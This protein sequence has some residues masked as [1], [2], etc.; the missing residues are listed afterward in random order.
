MDNSSCQISSNF[1]RF[2]NFFFYFKLKYIQ[3]F[4]SIPFKFQLGSLGSLFWLPALCNEGIRLEY[5]S[6]CKA[7]DFLKC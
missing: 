6:L 3:E 4:I 5:K 2:W 1:K 7:F